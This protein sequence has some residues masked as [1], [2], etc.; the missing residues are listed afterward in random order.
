[1]NEDD[2]PEE[3]LGPMCKPVTLEPG[4]IFYTAQEWREKRKH[5]KLKHTKFG[6]SASVGG[7]PD[8]DIYVEQVGDSVNPYGN[9]YHLSP[10]YMATLFNTEAEAEH[11]KISLCA[12]VKFKHLDPEKLTVVPVRVSELEA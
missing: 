1:M 2:L 12:Y 7:P 10:I 6:L 11:L 8:D 4:A 5:M 3:P 9:I